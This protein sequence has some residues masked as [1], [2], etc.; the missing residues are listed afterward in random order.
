MKLCIFPNDP[1]I[2]YYEKGEIKPRYYNPNNFFDEID[3][4][5]LTKKDVDESKVKI[6][7]G[8]A[9]LKIHSIGK[10]NI[11]NYKKRLNDVIAI[12]NE[13]NPDVIRTYNPFIEGWLAS[14]CATNLD[15]PLFV[16][17]HIQHDVLR[18]LYK[19]NNFKKYL[20]LKYCEKFI[21]PYVLKRANKITIVYKIIQSYV[22]RISEKDSELLYN[23]I[24]TKRFSN[25]NKIS[26]LEKPLIISVGRLTKQKN[27]ECLIK[28]ME[29]IDAHLLI[30]GDGELYEKLESMIKKLKL[31]KKISLKKSV[32]NLE[33]QNYY[34]SADV[35]AL[36]YDPELEGL[37]IPI[38]EAMASGLPIVIP[39]PKKGFSDGLDNV[40]IFSKRE[41]KSF[42][43]AINNILKNFELKKELSDKSIEKSKDFDDKIIENR[44]AQIYRNLL[45]NERNLIKI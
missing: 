13:I 35:F 23:R 37:P 30:I 1:I 33:I 9:T 25:A 14:K 40:A 4:I 44:E 38:M 10:I 20:A 19:K 12:V 27:H 3:I 21:E 34:K 45:N 28:S 18:K 11:K 22:Q 17:L 7:A 5:S 8:N 42:A 32:P 24:D 15:I 43:D 2:A 6:I 36:A 31:N 29:K 39:F 26:T 41:P 16:S